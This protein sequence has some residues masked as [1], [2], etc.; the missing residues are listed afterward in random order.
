[1]RPDTK[2]VA[3]NPNVTLYWLLIEVSSVIL[4]RLSQL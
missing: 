3:A 1:M 4:D 2:T